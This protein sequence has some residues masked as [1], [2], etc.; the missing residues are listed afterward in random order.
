M[1][2][3][4]I[5]ATSTLDKCTLPSLFVLVQ[6]DSIP[7]YYG[8]SCDQDLAIFYCFVPDTVVVVYAR[9]LGFYTD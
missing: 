3:A 5:S 9:E 4:E 8:F 2:R 1:R 7:E 6:V